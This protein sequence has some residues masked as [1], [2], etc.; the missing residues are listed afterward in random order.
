[1]LFPMEAVSEQ[2]PGGLVPPRVP[3]TERR[4]RRELERE[5]VPP[6]APAER[7]IT[8]PGAVAGDATPWMK[9]T[10]VPAGGAGRAPQ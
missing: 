7:A 6:S 2:A 9:V 10:L 4:F 3:A 1:M 8:R 5:L